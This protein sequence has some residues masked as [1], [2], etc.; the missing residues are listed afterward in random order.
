MKSAAWFIGRA[1]GRCDALLNR[2]LDR[3]RCRTFTIDGR[4]CVKHADHRR[5]CVFVGRS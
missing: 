3:E 2:L 5:A 4:Q 1:W